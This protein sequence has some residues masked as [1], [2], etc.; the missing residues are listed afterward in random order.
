M[1]SSSGGGAHCWDP[2][3][4]APQLEAVAEPKADA[5]AAQRQAQ[6]KTVVE[7]MAGGICLPFQLFQVSYIYMYICIIYIHIYIYI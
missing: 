3:A 2:K 6:P 1:P 4:L 5:D 7:P